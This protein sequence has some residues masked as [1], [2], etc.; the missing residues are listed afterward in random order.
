MSIRVIFICWGV[1]TFE[2][3]AADIQPAVPPPTMTRCEIFPAFSMPPSF[4]KKV[5]AGER[6]AG[7]QGA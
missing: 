7:L 5:P 4:I 3:K 6:P 1:N 2:K